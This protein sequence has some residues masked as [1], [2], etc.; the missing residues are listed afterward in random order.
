MKWVT[1]G[2]CCHKPGIKWPHTPRC[3]I[4]L[5]GGVASQETCLP[6]A[7]LG[8]SAFAAAKQ[9]TYFYV[10]RFTLLQVALIALLASLPAASAAS[11]ADVFRSL[12][13]RLV[14]VEGRIYFDKWGACNSTIDELGGPNESSTCST[15][16]S[17]QYGCF[18]TV[19]RGFGLQRSESLKYLQ[20]HIT[21][22]RLDDQLYIVFDGR[23]RIELMGNEKANALL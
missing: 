3:N 23:L 20:A 22:T 17:F 13:V 4:V 1:R 7:L 8:I 10:P 16:S 19:R 18:H 21:L 14:L 5:L 2:A 6:P 15:S 11:T 9:P 12:I